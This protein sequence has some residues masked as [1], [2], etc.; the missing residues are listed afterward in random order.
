MAI[1]I[2]QMLGQQAPDSSQYTPQDVARRRLLAE[3]LRGNTVQDA[4]AIGALAN[5]LSGTLSGYED[6]Q[7]AT[8]EAEGQKAARERLIAALNDPGGGVA[9]LAAVASDPFLSQSSASIASALLGQ[10]IEQQ[11]PMYQAQLAQAQLELDRARNPAPAAPDYSFTFAPDGT[12]IRTDTTSG[13]FEPMGQ[14][15][16]PEDGPLV[17]INT[18]DTNDF[19]KGLDT[20][21]GKQIPAA[22]EAGRNAVSNNIRLGQLETLLGPEGTAPQGAQGAFVQAAAS[23]GIPIEGADDVQAAQALI[24]QMVPGQRPPGSGTMSDQDLALFKASLPSIIN[25]PG[26]N[27]KIIQTTKAINEYIAEQ[28]RIAE[29]I[30]N[31]QIT[32]EEGARMQAAVPN[33]LA[34]QPASASDGDGW[35]DLGNGIR[36]RPIGQ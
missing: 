8:M 25:Q 15:A 19:Y 22:I 7:A 32:R 35:Q 2:A 17:N 5:T 21:A 34:V 30:A 1:N 14:F 3:R 6:A 31:R 12:L 16:A 13:V 29:M 11:D 26:G 4:G 10:K 20:E 18:G 28:G 36:I 24:N 9:G 33:P 23:F 27:Q